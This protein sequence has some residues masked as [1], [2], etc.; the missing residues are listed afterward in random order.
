MEEAK[1]IVPKGAY[2][3]ELVNGEGKLKHHRIS[4]LE[5]IRALDN[6]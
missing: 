2:E 3:F 5:F 6:K 4:E 1:A